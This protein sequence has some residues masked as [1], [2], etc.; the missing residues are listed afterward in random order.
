MHTTRLR[1]S[2]TSLRLADGGLADGQ[3]LTALRRRPGRGRLRG[4]G[5]PPRAD[6]AGRLPARAAQ[7]PGRRGRLP[8][9]LPRP[10]RKA[11]GGRRRE[12]VGSW[13]Y[14]VAYRTALRRAGPATRRPPERQVDPMPQ[15]EGRR[16]PAAGL[17][18]AAGPGAEPAAREVPRRRGA[19]R[20]GGAAA[21]RR[22]PGSSGLPEG[23]LSSRL[24]TAR[25]MLAAAGRL[26][27]GARGAPWR[28]R[29]RRGVGAGAGGLVA[30]T[31]RAA[32][33]VAAGQAAAVAT[34]AAL[35]LNEVLRAML[36]TKL[37]AYVAVALVAVVLCAWGLAYRA[38]GQDRP[39]ENRPSPRAAARPLSDLEVLKRRWPS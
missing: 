1:V 8:G 19:V 13:L 18:A 10:G 12:A 23:T 32:A 39:G 15:P 4:P 30:S 6:G 29:W 17:A 14:G 22:R 25:R 16:R 36:L 7:R 35:L 11:A 24:A 2:G 26:R 34:P 21:A 38:T 37:K 20:P 27:A 5:A 31:A 33:L 28:R 9:H 3:L